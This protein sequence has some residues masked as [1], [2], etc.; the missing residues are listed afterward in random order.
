MRDNPLPFFFIPF[1]IVDDIFQLIV[2][3]EYA[4]DSLEFFD[5][6]F[7]VSDGI[8]KFLFF[9]LVLVLKISQLNQ[10][11]CVFLLDLLE[12]KPHL[13]NFFVQTLVVFFNIEQFVFSSFFFFPELLFFL[14]LN[15]QF[16][17]KFFDLLHLTLIVTIGP[18]PLEI[19][20]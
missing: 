20:L 6:F 5:L 2:V 16:F 8:K 12:T 10:V 18:F 1:R 15:F 17:F 14:F 11:R 7:L 19:L 3:H 13:V 4:D 9:L